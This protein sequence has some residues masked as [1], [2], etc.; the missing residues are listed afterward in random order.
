MA[1][2]SRQK[3]ENLAIIDEFLQKL[4][5][6]GVDGETCR[7]YGQLKA[8]IMARFRPKKRSKRRHTRITDL[9]ISENDLWIASIALQ[10]SLTIVSEDNVFF[11]LKKH[12]TFLEKFGMYH[13]LR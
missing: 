9:G 1:A 4:S 12:E 6:Y 10:H 8:E 3:E 7:I 2:N 13:L 11:A 5:I